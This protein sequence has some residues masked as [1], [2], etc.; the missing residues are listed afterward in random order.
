MISKFNQLN[1]TTTLGVFDAETYAVDSQRILADQ[2]DIAY[3]NLSD[4]LVSCTYLNHEA[5]S[6]QT[7]DRKPEVSSATQKKMAKSKNHSQHV[8][9]ECIAWQLSG[10]QAF[11]LSIGYDLIKKQDDLDGCKNLYGILQ[12]SKW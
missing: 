2:I 6:P 3:T 4:A 12:S 11:I 1:A 7:N 9:F 10:F 5:V 8:L